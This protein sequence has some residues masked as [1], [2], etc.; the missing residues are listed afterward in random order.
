MALQTASVR[1][2]ARG[3]ILSDWRRDAPCGWRLDLPWT[4]IDV[5]VDNPVRP[6]FTALIEMR[7]ICSSCPVS[8]KCAYEAVHGEVDGKGADGGFYSGSWIPWKGQQNRT[9][10]RRARLVLEAKAAGK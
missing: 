4:G 1:W 3:R 9:L 10:R 6:G 5:G 7:A 2:A 8:A